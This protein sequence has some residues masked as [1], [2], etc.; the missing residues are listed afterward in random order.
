MTKAQIIATLKKEGIP[1]TNIAPRDFGWLV[2]IANISDA[3]KMWKVFPGC[4][5]SG[6]GVFVIED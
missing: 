4:V 5:R 6:L 2:C 3:G 1:Y